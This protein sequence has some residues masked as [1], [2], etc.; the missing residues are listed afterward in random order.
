[1]VDYFIPR[2]RISGKQGFAFVRFR[3]EAEA[4]AAVNL[5]AGRS[6]GGRKIIAEFACHRNQ[7][8]NTFVCISNSTRRNPWATLE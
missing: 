5:V 1:M 8:Q 3:S 2:D 7:K 4:M 6:W